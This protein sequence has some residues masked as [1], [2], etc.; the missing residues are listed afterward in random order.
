MHCN[1]CQ[2]LIPPGAA[3]CP[4][5]GL[6]VSYIGRA[7]SAP[8][9]GGQE[10]Q[11]PPFAFPLATPG[12]TREAYPVKYAPPAWNEQKI[13]RQPS[14]KPPRLSARR[15]GVLLLLFSL[16]LV[17]LSSGFVYLVAVVQ[18]AA[19]RAQ[20]TATAQALATQN[21]ANPA[22]LYNQVTGSA[23]SVDDPLKTKTNSSWGTYSGKNGGCAF[24]NSAY[25]IT[26][27]QTG[28]TACFDQAR[29]FS[30]FAFQV[31]MTI[32]KG[33]AGGLV[34]RLS[35]ANAQSQSFDAYVFTVAVIGTYSIATTTSQINAPSTSGASAAIA[36][37]V[38][39]ANLLTVIARGSSFYLYVNKKYVANFDDNR[40][41]AGSIGLFALNLYDPS[42]VMFANAQVWSL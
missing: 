6:P 38:G 42:E 19:T 2:I 8:L 41:S 18:P 9:P 13:A 15:K 23:P 22:A 34:F 25:H 28:L 7:D 40:Y 12:E 32:V 27:L 36:K 21:A 4:N 14:S 3:E 24:S 37:G 11:P 1:I 30:D 5:C 26:A 17:L 10:E 39:H 29:A 33:D 16:L 35:S 31:Q 20:A